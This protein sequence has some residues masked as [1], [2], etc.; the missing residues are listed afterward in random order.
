MV[1]KR[2]LHSASHRAAAVWVWPPVLIDLDEP[3]EQDSPASPSGYA[4]T[5]ALLRGAAENL[6]RPSEPPTNR[7]QKK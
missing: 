3:N 2:S 1:K 4:E 5:I 7:V 6:A